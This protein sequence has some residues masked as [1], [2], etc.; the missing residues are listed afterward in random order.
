M[1]KLKVALSKFSQ[2]SF[3]EN[4]TGLRCSIVEAREAA[5]KFYRKTLPKMMTIPKKANPVP[6]VN[7]WLWVVGYLRVK[8]PDVEKN[9][10]KSRQLLNARTTSLTKLIAFFE[11]FRPKY[12]NSLK[13]NDFW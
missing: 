8:W 12:L 5:E 13:V 4:P 10:A 6:K 7:V 2:L 11:K 3:R 9:L 1:S